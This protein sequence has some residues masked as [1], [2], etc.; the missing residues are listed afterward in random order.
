MQ[1]ESEFRQTPR[2]KC[3]S[4][5]VWELET[6]EEIIKRRLEKIQRGDFDAKAKR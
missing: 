4:K 6:V 1:K 2:E 3:V 5:I